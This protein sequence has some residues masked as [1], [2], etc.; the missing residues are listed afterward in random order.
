MEIT[1]E[2]IEALGFTFKVKGDDDTDYTFNKPSIRKNW[3][4]L[5]VWQPDTNEITLSRHSKDL[6]TVASKGLP[7]GKNI[8]D[9]IV[10]LFQSDVKTVAELKNLLLLHKII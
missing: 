2:N 1:K 10:Q 4:D 6:V 7:R 9:Y 8:S 3:V 5:L